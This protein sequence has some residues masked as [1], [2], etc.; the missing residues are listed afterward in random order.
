MKKK[1]L[2]A[3]DNPHILEV[4]SM[5]LETLD[6]RILMARD[7]EEALEQAKKERPDLI[8]LDIMMPKKN[9]F[10][11]CRELKQSREFREIPIV[12]LSAKA[13]KEDK[14]WG[15]DAGA[16][17]YITKPFDPLELERVVTRL[18]ELKEAG[19]GYHPLTRLPTH[20][21]MEREIARRKET[22]Q[23]FAICE[24]RFP[25]E[26]VHIFQQKYGSLKWEE[27]LAASA[28]ILREQ[29]ERWGGRSIYLGHRGESTLVAIGPPESLE[30][31]GKAVV[32]EVDKTITLYYN[33]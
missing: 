22:M 25:Q 20:P 18:L 7:G 29:A 28:G 14:F 21:S 5:T 6:Y 12:M 23:A 17:D 27:L 8:L 24:F 1:I 13:Q 32:E 9:G 16:D 26:A 33:E 31:M 10:E 15:R 11:V 3:D 30:K 2:V 4:V 19:E